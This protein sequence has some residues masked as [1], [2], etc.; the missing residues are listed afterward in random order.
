M[1]I[2]GKISLG[3]VMAALAIVIMT[4]GGMIPIATYVCPMLCCLLLSFVADLC[5]KRIGWAW[6]FSVSVLSLLLGPD[7]EAAAVFVALGYYP[8]LKPILDRLPVAWLFKL[9]LFNGATAI[10]YVVLIYL[11]GMEFLIAEFSGLGAFG[12]ILTLCLGNLCF[13]LLDRLLWVLR[14]KRGRRHGR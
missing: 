8:L 7:K 6:Y 10:L 3:G 9:M 11:A 12:W 1:R 4:L 5:G 14:H 13:L 2:S